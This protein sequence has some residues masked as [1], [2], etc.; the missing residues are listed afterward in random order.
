[1]IRRTKLY[2][3]LQF[4]DDITYDELIHEFNDDGTVVVSDKRGNALKL[5]L[6]SLLD[7]SGGKL[8]L[9]EDRDKVWYT[10]ATSL[11]VSADQVGVEFDFVAREDRVKVRIYGS[12]KKETT[13][14]MPVECET[15]LSAE[16]DFN[17]TKRI[18]S[19][20]FGIDGLESSV[21]FD[22]SDMSGT[23]VDGK[24]E[25]SVAKVFDIDPSTVGTS[26]TDQAINRP[27]QRKTFIAAGREWVFYSDGT[28]LLFMSREIEPLGNWSAA[29]TFKA[30]LARGYQ[31]SLWWDGTKVHV[32][33]GDSATVHYRSGTPSSDGTISWGTE[34]EVAAL[35]SGKNQTYGTVTVDSS[36]YPVVAYSRVG[37][38]KYI[39]YI[40]IATATDGSTWGSE[41]A[42]DTEGTDHKVQVLVLPLA[43]RELLAIWRDVV[44]GQ[45]RSKF[46]DGTNWG[47]IKDIASYEATGRS[48]NAIVLGSKVILVTPVATN[49]I[50]AYEWTED[51]WGAGTK[52][53]DGTVATISKAGDNAYAFV[54]DG[55]KL[56]RVPY[57]G[58]WG[59]PVEWETTSNW[60]NDENFS[61][62]YSAENGRIG[63]YW[64]EGTASPYNVQYKAFDIY[65]PFRS[66]YPHIL[67]R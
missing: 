46:Y 20:T 56:Y 35:V 42:L 14:R 55:T 32:Q 33:Y 36:D 3:V 43:D 12:L 41:V 4:G 9:R 23:W 61:C 37:T 31:M 40:K 7:T 63:V 30:G 45:L 21:A 17:E 53:D 10:L 66:I 11:T 48:W 26:T 16:R 54:R 59:T 18:E 51:D 6:E 44:T 47:A 34:R 60:Q 8:E 24:L 58:T 49:D 13:L 62:G 38:A 2:P 52:I 29:T 27:S 5:H 25:T 65:H 22:F 1:M 57:T 19:A 67:I 39:P 50:K 64:L 28:D 15:K